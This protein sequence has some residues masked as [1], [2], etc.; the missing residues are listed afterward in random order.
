MSVFDI[1]GNIITSCRDVLGN[2]PTHLFDIFGNTLSGGTSGGGTSGD[3]SYD[4]SVMTYNIQYWG[5]GNETVAPTIF[6]TYKPDIVAFQEHNYPSGS[7][8]N[9]LERMKPITEEFLSNAGKNYNVFCGKSTSEGKRCH[10]YTA[11][12]VNKNMCSATDTTRI[13]Y[14]AQATSGIANNRTFDKYIASI[15]GRPVSIYNTHLEQSNGKIG[16]RSAKE[17]QAEELF[18]YIKNNETNPFVI[19]GDF[20]T[21]CD[22]LNNVNEWENTRKTIGRF[23]GTTDEY[24]DL[25]Y[26]VTGCT[27]VNA[28]GCLTCSLGRQGNCL[29]ENIPASTPPTNGIC[30]ASSD[31]VYYT[32]LETNSTPKWYITD[33]IIV[34][35]ELEIVSAKMD[36]SKNEKPY[37]DHRPLIAYLKFKD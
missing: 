15:K 26:E 7:S 10:S 11:L 3:G 5:A 2:T 8:I 13:G 24:E 20:N 9:P 18:N 17:A 19:M 21:R 37:A 12:A 1:N 14:S 32:L 23:V 22:N 30:T 29:C 16:T 25:N 34:S 33:N 27:A 4:F 6:G 35:P 31:N 36:T 28:T